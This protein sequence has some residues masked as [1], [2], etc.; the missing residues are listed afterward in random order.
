MLTAL[1]ARI[2]CRG[3]ILLWSWGRRPVFRLHVGRRRVG[4]QEIILSCDNGDHCAGAPWC[5]EASW[6]EWSAGALDVGARV[7]SPDTPGSTQTS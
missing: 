2:Y 4:C 7:V 6:G 1:I 5:A 3:R